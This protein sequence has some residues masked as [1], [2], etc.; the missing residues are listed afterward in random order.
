LLGDF[1]TTSMDQKWGVLGMSPDWGMLKLAMVIFDRLDIDVADELVRE[2]IT[3]GESSLSLAGDLVQKAG[4]TEEAQTSR[5]WA[6]ASRVTVAAAL[7]QQLRTFGQG[8]LEQAELASRLMSTIRHIE[9][10]EK[11]RELNWA[12]ID[13]GPWTLEDVLGALVP[14]G[15]ASDGRSSWP[16]MGEFSLGRVESLLGVDRVLEKLQPLPAGTE[17]EDEDSF[18]RRRSG[19][20]LATRTDYA[21]VSME[22]IRRERASASETPEEVDS[23]S[24]AESPGDSAALGPTT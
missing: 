22:R 11:I 17:L 2:L 23:D 16:S 15:S 3:R 21:L 18:E 13:S 20:D 6:V 9:G 4:T 7:E 24:N 5:P 1:Y 12:L 10:E 19:V 8:P 14:V